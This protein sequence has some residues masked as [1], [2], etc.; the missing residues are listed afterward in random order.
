VIVND[1]T[2]IIRM[3]IVS[4]ATISVSLMVV[5]YAPTVVNFVPREQL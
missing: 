1:I 2:K 3:M 5:N 4:D